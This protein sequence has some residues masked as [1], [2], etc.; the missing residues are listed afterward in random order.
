MKMHLKKID[1][2]A[3]GAETFFVRTNE[4][5]ELYI[6]NVY[7]MFNLSNE[8]YPVDEGVVALIDNY[9]QE[10]DIKDVLSEV[11]EKYTKAVTKDKKLGKMVN[12]KIP[13]AFYAWV[14]EQTSNDTPA[15]ADSSD[16]QQADNSSDTTSKNDTASAQEQTDESTASDSSET[17]T[18][19]KNKKKKKNK[20][21]KKDT[22]TDTANTS[23]ETQDSTESTPD[24]SSSV[25]YF[26][27]GEQIRLTSATVVRVS[28]SETASRVG[29]AYAGEYL[30]VIMSYQEGWT[31]VSWGEKTGYVKTEVLKA[32]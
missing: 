10:S 14:Q 11:Q 6:D 18:K 31:K 22:T 12:K 1:T 21:K 30:T 15:A 27:V 2:A 32:Q 8:E 4:N 7:S 29:T 26:S 3:P 19:K 24:S 16:T 17:T 13:N 25:P 28:M 9:K 5:G 20:N 23:E